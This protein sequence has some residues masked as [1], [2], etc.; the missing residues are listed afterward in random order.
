MEDTVRNSVLELARLLEEHR[1]EDVRALYVGTMS[2]WTDYF[3]IATVRSSAHLH[4]LLRSVEEFFA[5]KHI[6]PLTPRKHSRR[7]EGWVLID[8]GPFVL[9]LFDQEHREFYELEK[10]WFKN[11]LIYSSKSS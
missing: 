9:H 10:L 5:E 4:G 1:G 2:N 3:V 8:C 7:E 11:E 6:Q